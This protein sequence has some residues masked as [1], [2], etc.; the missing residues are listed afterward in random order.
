MSN[1]GLA[2]MITAVAPRVRCPTAAFAPSRQREARVKLPDGYG[3]RFQN[4]T[5]QPSRPRSSPPS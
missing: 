1:A 3:L 2:G 4:L 5:V